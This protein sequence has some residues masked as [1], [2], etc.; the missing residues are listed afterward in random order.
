MGSI[1]EPDSLETTHPTPSLS[2]YLLSD[3]HVTGSILGTGDSA[4]NKTDPSLGSHR[5]TFQGDGGKTDKNKHRPGFAVTPVPL[6]EGLPGRLPVL[7]S[8]G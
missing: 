5:L 6:G 4:V 2:K 3:Y 8:V 1:W 7:H